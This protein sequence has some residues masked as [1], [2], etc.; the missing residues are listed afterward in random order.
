VIKAV[1]RKAREYVSRNE[2][3]SGKKRERGGSERG[4]IERGGTRKR[5]NEE[6]K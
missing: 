2:G 3:G 1:R 6:Q 5:R 4:G